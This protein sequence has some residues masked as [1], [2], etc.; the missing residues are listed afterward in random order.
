MP[1]DTAVSGGG[2]MEDFAQQ[3]SVKP[4]VNFWLDKVQLSS[5]GRKLSLIPDP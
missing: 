2:N 1:M 4:L 5:D 3:A